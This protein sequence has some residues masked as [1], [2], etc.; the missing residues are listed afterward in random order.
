MSKKWK[1]VSME[2]QA[3]VALAVLRNEETVAGLAAK[4]EVHATMIKN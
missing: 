4:F 1:Q 2:F 3:K